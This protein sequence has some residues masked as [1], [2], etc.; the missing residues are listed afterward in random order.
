MEKNINRRKTCYKNI[1]KKINLIKE[2]PN[3]AYS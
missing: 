2:L 3:L 1:F